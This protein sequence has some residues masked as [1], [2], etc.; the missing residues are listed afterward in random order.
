MSEAVSGFDP[1]SLLEQCGPVSNG[2]YEQMVSEWQE[3]GILCGDAMNNGASTS[4]LSGAPHLRSDMQ[5]AL[6][7]AASGSFAVSPTVDVSPNYRLVGGDG[8]LGAQ[9]GAAL[10]SAKS[11]ASSGTKKAKKH[12]AGGYV[13]GG[14]QLSW[15]AEEGYGE[16]VIPTNPSRRTRAL[17]LYQQAGAALGVTA[18]AAG[19]YV[20][21]AGLAGYGAGSHLLNNIDG[22][23]PAAGTVPLDSSS[24]EAGVQKSGAAP[25]EV[26]VSVAP[27]FVIQGGGGQDEENIMQVIRRHM[28]EIADELGGEIAGKLEEVFSNMPIKEA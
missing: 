21:G 3:A 5:T 24:G 27:E 23:V 8:G 9:I 17:D 20:G 25:V 26:H 12:A 13:S 1:S 14:P 18:H 22:G 16:F 19:G 11:S 15:L 10:S 6:D 4:L 2:Y 28:R 7:S